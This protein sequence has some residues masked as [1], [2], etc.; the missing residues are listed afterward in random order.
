[1]CEDNLQSRLPYILTLFLPL[2][3]PQLNI[4]SSS[5]LWNR[6][7]SSPNIK[8]A[9][10]MYQTPLGKA[11]T[12]V[13]TA[14]N[15]REKKE[16]QRGLLGRFRAKKKEETVERIPCYLFDSYIEPQESNPYPLANLG[17]LSG[18]NSFT[19]LHLPN[20]P[21]STSMKHQQSFSSLSSGGG[22]PN[23]VTPSFSFNTF[24]QGS[25][26]QAR[27][28]GANKPSKHEEYKAQQH[29]NYHHGLF[30]RHQSPSQ[31]TYHT[32]KGTCDWTMRR[33]YSTRIWGSYRELSPTKYHSLR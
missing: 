1:M 7:S 30:H 24:G 21:S 16:K 18:S 2:P 6:H 17:V 13:S 10:K 29:H 3:A 19:D 12:N 32:R 14:S 27:C 25:T 33:L 28:A 31:A 23:Q 20:N 5:N 9:D 4:S 15:S 26:P 8:P 22:T 11:T